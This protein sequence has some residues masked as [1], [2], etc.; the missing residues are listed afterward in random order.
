MRRTL[1]FAAVLAVLSVGLGMT[2]DTCT[3]SLAEPWRVLPMAQVDG[4]GCTTDDDCGCDDDC[5]DGDVF[6]WEV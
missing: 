6:E 1:P 4:A 2:L 3:A 5:L